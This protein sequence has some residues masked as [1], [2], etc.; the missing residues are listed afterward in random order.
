MSTSYTAVQNLVE[1]PPW[2]KE[3]KP[4]FFIYN[5]FYKWLTYR[6]DRSPDFH[7]W[8]LKWHGLTQGCAFFRFGWCGS[9]YR[10]S[11]SPQTSIFRAW[12]GFFQPNVPNIETFILSKQ[13]HN[14]ILH[15]D[16]DHR[17]LYMGGPNVPKQIQDA[18]GRHLQ[19]MKNLSISA[20]DWPIL[21]TFDTVMHFSPLDPLR[22]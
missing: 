12:I 8:W 15:S 11:K 17:V 2:W 9:P 5:T 21:T 10:G 19:K 1:I 20:T 7:A 6:S 14:Q 18:D 3:I 13:L 4:K 22:Q 16:R